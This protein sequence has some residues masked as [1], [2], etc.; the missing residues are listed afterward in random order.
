MSNSLRFAAIAVAA[1]VG[2][3]TSTALAD[4]YFG[5]SVKDVPVA[6]TDTWSGLYIGAAVGYGVATTEV[7]DTLSLKHKYDKDGDGI[8]IPILNLDGLS[9]EGALGTLTLG[10]DHQ[11][12]PGILVGIFGDYTFG[13]LEHETSVLGGL[14]KV[15]SSLGDNWS[16]GARIGLIRDKTLWYAMAGYTESDLDWSLSVLGG[17]VSGGETLSGYFVGLGVEHQIFNNV[18]LKL[19]YRFYDYD[20][21]NYSDSGKFL[22][23]EWKNNLEIDTDV[24]AVRV[25]LNWKFNSFDAPM[26]PAP[27]K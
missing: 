25:G 13:D 22:C 4:G 15:E 7:N 17:E 21:L 24:H 11:I 12:S 8:K 18:S 10:Y 14:G 16:I 23:L 19:D 3:G 26:S 5:G 1:G 6:V 9:S 20:A 27:L 2:L